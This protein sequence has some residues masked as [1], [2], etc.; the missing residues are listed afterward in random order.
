MSGEN[1]GAWRVDDL[2]LDDL[3]LRYRRGGHGSPVLLLHGLTDAAGTWQQVADALARSHEVIVPDQRGHGD[4]SAPDGG[5]AVED[6]VRDA[7][8]LITALEIAPAAVVGH[9]LGG[10]IALHLAASHPYLVSRLVVEDPPLL[11]D[12]MEGDV[13]PQ[14]V[15]QRR[16]AWFA[17]VIEIR[18][19]SP[20]DRLRHI[21]ERSPNWQPGLYAA[22]VESKL[23]MSP[24][25]WKPGGV[26]LRGDWQ[27]ALRR[28]RC[29]LL[30][31]R[32]E[33][34]LGSLV[35]EQRE[36]EVLDL[37]RDSR[38]VH[39]PGAA[40]AVHKDAFPA[41]MA[42]VA[43]FLAEGHPPLAPHPRP[44]PPQPSES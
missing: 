42:V 11:P 36:R 4:S 39:I 20:G 9:S 43:P 8:A 14:E 21:Q 23:A 15:D 30:L 6:F 18:A 19:M 24:R 38:A 29:P 17:S 7:A 12:W 31:V 5:Y 44:Y 37:V 10:L 27:A 40:H 1:G 32:G 25:L 34:A 22:W 41:F 13:S 3:R 26:D 28:V 16:A 33:S 35:D 2:V